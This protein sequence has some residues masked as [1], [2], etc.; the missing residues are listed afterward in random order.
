MLASFEEGF[1]TAVVP[2]PETCP[3]GAIQSFPLGLT[4]E[5]T[6]ELYTS[7][8]EPMAID[9]KWGSRANPPQFLTTEG[10]KHHIDEVGAGRTNLSTFKYLNTDYEIIDVQICRATHNNWIIPSSDRANNKEDILISFEAKSS[11]VDPRYKYI[12]FVIPVVREEA[13]Q[14]PSYLT[15]LLNPSAQGPFSVRSCFP[16]NPRSLFAYYST[17]LK[18]VTEDYKVRNAYIFVS[19][20]GVRAS[21]ATMDALLRMQSAGSTQFPLPN[22]PFTQ[23]FSEAARSIGVDFNQF[24]LSTDQ[25]LNAEQYGRF[26]KIESRQDDTSAYK[27]VPLN[28]DVAVEG[29][30][31]EIDLESG[32]PLKEVLAAREA[33]KT[34]GGATAQGGGTA[35]SGGVTLNPGRLEKFV[36]SAVGIILIILIV[37]FVIIVITQYFAP[38]NPAT[39]AAVGAMTTGQ[40]IADWLQ[41]GAFYA[42]IIV[43]AGFLGFII[44]AMLG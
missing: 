32:L 44:G 5:V 19:V 37:L 34:A 25:L 35:A 1:Q 31:L 30:K 24:V 43:L 2:V 41:S 9:F 40:K 3:F 7:V 39:A 20:S 42:M 4:V 14:D 12:L 26:A 28:P 27:C 38:T 18:G 8:S 22:P 11:A 33:E 23:R 13:A 15:G 17:C 6:E 10:K 21:T 16:T 29:D 36:S